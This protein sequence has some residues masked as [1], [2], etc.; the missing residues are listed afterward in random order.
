MSRMY[1]SWSLTTLLSLASIGAHAAQVVEHADRA[2]VQV[3]VS[4]KEQNRLSVEG[5][6]IAYVVPSQK[7]VLSYQQDEGNGVFYFL[8]AD[9]HYTGTTT[10]FVTD[11]Q[12]VNYTLL[13]VPR[14]VA[15]EDITIRPP[16]DERALATEGGRTL[17]YQRRVKGLIVAMDDPTANTRLETTAVNKVVPLWKEGA[18]ILL[19]RFMDRDLVGEKYRL[20][21]ISPADMILVEQELYRK[22]VLAVSIETHTLAPGD[23]TTIYIVRG[24]KPNE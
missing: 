22:G 3:T 11:D 12:G 13:M 19:S 1:K 8:L 2:T 15:A 14:P 9:E 24:R 5:R 23:T 20:T 10:V 6:R 17:A 18:L 16:R 7:G 4:I 21:N